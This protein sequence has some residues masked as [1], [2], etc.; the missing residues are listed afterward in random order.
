MKRPTHDC[1]R[2]SAPIFRPALAWALCALAGCTVGPDYERPALAASS[3]YSQAPLPESTAAAAVAAGAAQRLAL[4]QDIQ[5][6]WWTLFRSPALNALIERAFAANPDI[7]AAQAALRVAQENVAAQRGF[8]FPTV[9]ADYTPMRSKIA[10]NLGGNSPGIQGDGSVIETYA[11]TPR[12]EGGTAPFNGPVI[13]NFHTAQL[14]VGFVPDLFGANRRQVESLQAEAEFQRLQLEAAYITLASNVVA[15]AIQEALLR[16]QIAS[17]DAIIDGRRQ[18][19]AL[20]QRQQRAGYASRLDLALQEN[21]LAQARQLLPALERQF[22]QTRALLRALLGATQDSELPE[23]FELDALQLPEALPLTLPSRLVEQRPDVRAAEALLRSANAQVGVATAAMLPQISLDGAVGG[24]A[25]HFDQM[26]WKSGKFFD[27]EANISQPLFAGGT[28]LHRN[29]RR[30][31]RGA[32][33]RRSTAP[34]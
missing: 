15:A 29:A 27:L 6:D 31:R 26:L 22:E 13:Y 8:F 32:W 16:R 10:G 4:T 34:L 28:L 33:R 17:V 1:G 11:G 12:S 5:A 25:S 14:T 7:E 23:T 30:N 19:V 24:A 2:A 18:S 20:A 21:A 9:Q 3:G